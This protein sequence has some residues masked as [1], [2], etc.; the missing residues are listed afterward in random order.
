MQM[1]EVDMSIPKPLVVSKLL[2]IL[3]ASVSLKAH[4]LIS[5][6]FILVYFLLTWPFYFDLPITP[7]HLP[8]VGGQPRSAEVYQGTV[9]KQLENSLSVIMIQSFW[10]KNSIFYFNKF[11]MHACI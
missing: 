9:N 6:T 10:K 8:P 5:L 2:C 4:S 1:T 3:Y 7:T 11:Y